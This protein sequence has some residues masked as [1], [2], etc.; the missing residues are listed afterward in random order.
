MKR[1]FTFIK[2]NWWSILL[3]LIIG[4]SLITITVGLR[5]YYLHFSKFPEST[6]PL[7]W[8]S[9]GGYI[10]GI[11]SPLIAI[12]NICI[13]I[14]LTIVIR[15]IG[16]QNNQKNIDAQREIVRMQLRYEVLKE[17]KT[18]LSS[19]LIFW[20]TYPNGALLVN[21]LNEMKGILEN[22]VY[23]YD[24]LFHNIQENEYYKVSISILLG[25]IES[26]RESNFQKVYNNYWEMDNTIKRFYKSLIELT[27]NAQ[28]TTTAHTQ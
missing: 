28:H 8:G 26:V 5:M 20:Q 15:K 4:S 13:T 6:D 9:F 25:T 2:D 7:I 16:N 1:F 11:L 21:K 27:I 12:I 17:L 18:S 10:S 23:V 24:N 22:F 14:W 3:I 19:N